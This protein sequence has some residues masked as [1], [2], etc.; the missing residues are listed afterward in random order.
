MHNKGRFPKVAARGM[1][2]NQCNGEPVFRKIQS[3]I[4]EQIEAGQLRT[5]DPV[6]SERELARIH[7]VSLMTA[8]HALADLAREGLV[9]RRRGAGTSVAPPKIHFNKLTSYTEQMASRALALQSR[10]V[11]CGVI[12]DQEIAAR[13]GLAATALLVKLERVRTAGCEP[14]AVETCYLPAKKF[15][16]L[17]VRSLERGSMFATLQQKYGI[18]IS[19]ADEEI[20]ATPADHRMA[21]LLDI[22][23][24]SPLLRIRQV[25]YSSSGESILYVFGLYRS[26]KHNLL[27]R[28][29]R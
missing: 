15:E 18:E 28:R 1:K 3:A 13:L 19:Y 25:I 14:F 20:D 21:N 29:Y 23:P 24:G 10:I 7:Q 16:H 9:Q 11:D 17:P 6:D 27:I 22:E 4:P 2:Q 8:R 5:D 26:E 12:R